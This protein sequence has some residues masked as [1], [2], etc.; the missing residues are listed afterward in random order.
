MTQKAQ[1][2]KKRTRIQERNERRILEAALGVF[3][4]YGFR[5]ST[6]DQIAEKS[7]MS[8]PNLLYYFAG[9][10]D[11]YIALLKRTLGEWLEPLTMLDADGDPAEEIWKYIERK[12]ALS[13]TSPAASRLF[14]NEMVQG[15]PRIHKILVNQ[16]KPLMDEKCAIIQNW[17]DSG[18]L[19]PVEPVHL[20]Y[21]IWAATQ[22]YADFEAQ[23]DT[24]SPGPREQ[25]FSDASETL[26]LV[27]LNGILPRS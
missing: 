24:V 17:I 15:A 20:I 11:I 10:E 18:K 27:F 16:L 23:I 9:K 5:G 4:S 7:E 12:L 21:M 2:S 6:I 13:R 8:K 3:S 26:K 19:A 14:A 22:H 25:R 1:H